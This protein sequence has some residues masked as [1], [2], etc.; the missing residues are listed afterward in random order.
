[1]NAMTGAL[2]HRRRLR[3]DAGL[4]GNLALVLLLAALAVA[5]ACSQAEPW[6]WQLPGTARLW[7]AGA[8]LLGQAALIGVV[9]LRALTDAGNA[10]QAGLVGPGDAE[11]LVVHASQTGQA[12]ALARQAADALRVAGSAVAL[13]PLSAL[14]HATLRH[15]R[16]LLLVASTTGEGDPP[17]NAA[18]FVRQCL[19]DASIRLGQLEYG[20]LALGDRAYGDFCA[21][22]H[23][24]DDWFQRAGARPLFGMIEVDDHEPAALQRWRDQLDRLGV[25]V[26]AVGDGPQAQPWRLASRTLLNPGSPGA[27]VHDL[28]LEPASGTVPAWHAGD[29]AVLQ[30]PG[31]DSPREY[32]IASIPAEGHLRLLVRE[33]QRA[34]GSPGLGSGWLARGLEV[35][36]DVQVRIRSNPRFHAPSDA[37]PLVLVGN[38]TGVAGLRALLRE[39]IGAGR[40]RNWL[41]LGERT[42]AHDR[43]YGTELE[44][45]RERGAL[46]R[47][48]LAFSRDSGGARYVQDLVGAHGDELRRWIADGASIHVCGSL[49]GMAPGVDAALEALLGREALERL[50]ADG[51]YCRDVY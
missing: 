2:S 40:H 22:G 6:R 23:M 1:M 49:R 26:G 15:A 36:A 37:R 24:L 50:A 5:L 43:H 44:H 14:D 18:R 29:I 38:G 39:R 19:G 20:L 46:Q 31:A 8:L 11:W 30:P 34:D 7:G 35:G 42:A 10:A 51:R 17:D 3:V 48:D 27:P 28:V 13:L 16:R 45:W 47:L 33:Q 9:R 25:R 21:F 32:S 12:E 41:L 4:A